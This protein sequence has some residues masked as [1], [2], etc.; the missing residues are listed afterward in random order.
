MPGTTMIDGTFGGGGHTRALLDAS[1]PDGRV[2]ALDADPEAI[3]RGRVM[4]AE[5]GDRLML[6]HANFA[7]MTE[8]AAAVGWEPGTLATILL[9]L[10]LSS[11]QLATAERGFSFMHNGPLDMRF[12]TTGGL[13]AAEIVNTWDETAMADLFWAYGEE[14]ASR[15]VAR[16][17]V[18]RRA[19]RPFATTLQ[20]AD[21]VVGAKGGRRGRIHPATQV[22]QAL[23][24]VVNDEVGV[25][26]QALI[27]ARDLLR[28]GGRLAVISFHSLED[29]AVKLF[30]R[31]EASATEP[32][33]LPRSVPV[34][35]VARTPILRILTPRPV[36]P[37][38]EEI[39]ANPRARSAKLR[40][41]E[42]RVPDGGT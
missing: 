6:R 30:F 3:A 40:V 20:L 38:A 35:P 18:Q 28:P 32:D 31:H 8:A 4:Q 19:D 24:I 16:V 36:V 23:R 34:Q 41:A 2:L 42:K 39:A 12:D 33:M 29:R 14:P 15:R 10:G 9:D 26:E 11:F 21:A 25:L 13:S 1:A 22:F 37:D 5:F 7:R 27:A 17:I